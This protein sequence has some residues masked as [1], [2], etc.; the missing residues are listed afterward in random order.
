[1]R[2]IVTLAITALG[3]LLVVGALGSSALGTPTAQ[4]EEESKKI[5][6]IVSMFEGSIL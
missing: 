4:A 5:N 1:M 2:R 3:V 6:Q